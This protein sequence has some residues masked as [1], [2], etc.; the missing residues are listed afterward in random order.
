MGFAVSAW[1]LIV[2]RVLQG[3]ATGGIAAPT[4]ALA[5]DLSRAGTE[6][7]QM[8]VV[9]AG[10]ALGVSLGTL[11]AGVLAV[12]SLALPFLVVGSLNLLAAL[13]V[14]RIV[15]ETVKRS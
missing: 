3:I 12:Y 11:S 15:P 9:T 6:G 10:F 14:Y 8:S 1:Q 7:R 13:M 4:F 5:G 2:L